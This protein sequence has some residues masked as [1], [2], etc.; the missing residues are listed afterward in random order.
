M[1]GALPGARFVYQGATVDAL[2]PET[3]RWRV[4]VTDQAA[5]D[6]ALEAE[7]S[8]FGGRPESQRL[9]AQAIDTTRANFDASELRRERSHRGRHRL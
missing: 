5:L 8:H 4:D 3:K 6:R 2:L 7:V 1:L 9:L